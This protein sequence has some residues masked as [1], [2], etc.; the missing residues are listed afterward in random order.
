MKY[1]WHP[2]KPAF[3]DFETISAC[4]LSTTHK[5]AT[6]ESTGALT[7]VLKVDGISHMFGPYLQGPDFEKLAQLTEG[8]T[9]VAHNEPFDRAIWDL[10][11][12]LP[13]REWFDTLKPA[14]ARGLPGKLDDIGKI[15]LGRGKNEMGKKLIDML[16]IVRNGKRVPA[17]PAHKLLLTYNNDDVELLEGIYDEVKDYVEPDVMTVDS[18]INER[19]VPINREMLTGLLDVYETHQRTAREEFTERVGKINPGSHV[20]MKNW[21]RE[22]GFRIPILNERE[23]IGKFAFKDLVANPEDY[24]TGDDSEMAGSI[25]TLIEVMQMRRDIVR[26][27]KSKAERALEAIEHDDR[28]RE[29][30]VYWKAHPG[31]WAGRGLQLHNMPHTVKAVDVRGLGQ[32]YKAIRKAAAE[33]SER[34]KTQIGTSDV[35]N[36]MLRH[37]VQHPDMCIG[38]YAAV[39]AR[40]LAWITGCQKQLG[41]YMRDESVYLDM[42][43]SVFGRPISKADQQE[44]IIAKTLVLGCGYGMSGAKFEFTCKSRGIS[45]EAFKSMGMKVGDAVKQYRTTYPEIPIG[46]KLL[47]NAVHSAV[48]GVPVEACRCKFYMVGPDMKCELPSGRCIVYR[49]ARLEMLVPG[50]CKLYNMPEVPVPTVVF[51]LPQLWGD[52]CKRGFLY[53]SKICENV[54][55][56]ICRDFVAHALVNME[57]AGLL[58]FLHVHD[59]AGALCGPSRF[60]E[61]MEVLS[62][63]PP[64]A[65]GMPLGAEGYCGPVW[66]KQTN[67][68]PEMHSLNGKIT[69]RVGC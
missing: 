40:C 30:F 39:E 24:Y 12:K 42:G 48:G 26:V 54:C 25:E 47:H 56:G 9:I 16:C 3:L 14:R 66:T 34:T 1:N 59:E 23:S 27:G 38:D 17:G 5:Y 60:A 29:Q 15:L 63:L 37:L 31:R 7:A 46:W 69:K 18:I 58:P 13:E 10:T 36:A 41:M 62:V 19:G 45:V 64:W 20:Q 65:A 43:K 33:A 68:Y 4:P 51:D 11:C 2:S 52:N 49:N 21:M 50:Y 53:G 32:D 28:V 57:S 55:Q 35:L 67:G 44:Y 6:H 61:F 22:Q 8:R